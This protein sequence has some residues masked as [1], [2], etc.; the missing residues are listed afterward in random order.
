M[1]DAFSYLP[2]L[3]HQCQ[4]NH[5]NKIIIGSI[6]TFLLISLGVAVTAN[7]N[8][9][10]FKQTSYFG[11]ARLMPPSKMKQVHY[12]DLKSISSVLLMFSVGLQALHNM[13]ETNVS[14]MRIKQLFENVTPLQ[15]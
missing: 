11:F 12:S 13:I 8:I 1:F 9:T 7:L 4:S 10:D 3:R 6:F 15:T 2:D 5:F 14:V